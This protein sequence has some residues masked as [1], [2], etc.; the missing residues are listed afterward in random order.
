MAMLSDVHKEKTMEHARRFG[1]LWAL[2]IIPLTAVLLIAPQQGEV[3]LFKVTQLAI[4]VL[5]GYW[6]D[7]VVFANAPP[8]RA[9]MPRDVVS[10]ARLLARAIV[11][12]FIIVGITVGI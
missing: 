3:L 7:R 2:A 12:G 1:G 5:I 9:K 10:A 4:A 11:Q 6:A 8:I